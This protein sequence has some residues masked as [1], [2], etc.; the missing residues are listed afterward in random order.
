M[1]A[2]V[3]CKKILHWETDL[4]FATEVPHI[5][6]IGGESILIEPMVLIC[7]AGTDYPEYI[8]RSELPIEQEVYVEWTSE[9]PAGTRIFG[10]PTLFQRYNQ[11]LWAS[12][13]CSLQK[14][15]LVDRPT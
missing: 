14:R 15:L 9:L 1:I 13:R 10:V 8:D 4:A 11:R 2:A 3:V 6:E 7:A 12:F 5:D